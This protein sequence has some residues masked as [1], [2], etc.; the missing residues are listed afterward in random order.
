LFLP[1]ANKIVVLVI[2]RNR[3][4]RRWGAVSRNVFCLDG[5]L[6]A[7]VA[8]PALPLE[9]GAVTV[10]AVVAPAVTGTGTIFKAVTPEGKT[11][12]IS[13]GDL[14]ARIQHACRGLEK[15]VSS[16]EILQESLK[17]FYEGIKIEE[18][19]QANI[20]AARAKIEK[21]PAYSYV[22]ARLLLDITY[23]ET[24]GVDA[25]AKN[26]EKAHQD[27]FKACL[28]KGVS[29]ER[30]DPKL[31]EFD[32]DK[33]AKA[34]KLERDLEFQYLGLQTLYDRY[35]IHHEDVR[36]ETP[37]LLDARRYGLECERGRAE[38]RASNRVLRCALE[39]PLHL[40]YA[41]AL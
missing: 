16:E 30:M 12:S 9:Q 6:L 8:R 4:E 32:L 14:R 28:K 26:L 40:K 11:V 21:D 19:D 24:I 15:L 39:V 3:G 2:F 34:L 37:H 23:R 25:H 17:N 29:V 35:L 7:G 27:Y 22:A 1:V 18:I 33:L 38:E 36:L 41:N 5:I 13:E 20:M 31:L 10:E